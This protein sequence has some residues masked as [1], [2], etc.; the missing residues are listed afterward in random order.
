MW[1]G[2]GNRR[3]SPGSGWFAVAC[4]HYIYIFFIDNEPSILLYIHGQD[5][6]TLHA[7][8]R[9]KSYSLVALS[10]FLRVVF[11]FQYQYIELLHLMIFKL[12]LIF[13]RC[14]EVFTLFIRVSLKLSIFFN[15]RRISTSLTRLLN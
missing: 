10:T 13:E 14:R 5:V 8:V 9:K 4:A 7:R 2:K 11:F 6:L 3:W 12:P 1:S 15:V